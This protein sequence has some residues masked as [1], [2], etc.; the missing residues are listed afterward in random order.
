MV[1]E[2]RKGGESL[3]WSSAHESHCWEDGKECWNN[4]PAWHLKM[5]E[6]KYYNFAEFVYEMCYEE[7]I[8]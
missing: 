1:K 3:H 8:W 5:S 7:T 2:K 4:K 6:A